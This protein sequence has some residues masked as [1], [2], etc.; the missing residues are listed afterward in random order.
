MKRLQLLAVL[1]LVQF[2]GLLDPTVALDPIG[3]D[4]E[5][6]GDV[7]ESVTVKTG[8]LAIGAD[9]RFAEFA[10]ELNTDTADRSKIVSGK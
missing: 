5:N 9:A 10:F 1:L 2:L 3:R 4:I 6:R 7:L 8:D